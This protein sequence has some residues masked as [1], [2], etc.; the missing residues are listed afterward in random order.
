MPLFGKSSKS[1]SDVVRSLKDALITLEKGGQQDAKKMEKVMYLGLRNDIPIKYIERIIQGSK[2]IMF[3]IIQAQE[4]L[5]KQLL[6]MK[7]LLFGADG[8]AGAQAH[9]SSNTEGNQS[10]IVLA[11]LSQ[12]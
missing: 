7:N 2:S 1:P 10:D 9:S 3:Y 11:Q 6:N 4:D 12:V 8:A 5:S